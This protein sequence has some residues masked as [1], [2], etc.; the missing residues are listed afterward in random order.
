MMGHALKDWNVDPRAWECRDADTDEPSELRSIKPPFPP[1][2][3]C[4]QIEITTMDDTERKFIDAYPPVPGPDMS[5]PIVPRPGRSVLEQRAREAEAEANRS[6][7]WRWL[8]GW[9]TP[10]DSGHG[11][12]GYGH[13]D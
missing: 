12:T 9:L 6:G 3:D 1:N 4:D 2:V 8:F 5:K 13:Q 7:F 11:E 10:S